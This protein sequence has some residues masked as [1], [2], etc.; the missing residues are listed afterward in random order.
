VDDSLPLWTLEE[1]D[2]NSLHLSRKFVCKN[3]HSALDC[4]NSCGAIAE[5][6]G[7]HPDFHVTNYREV[8]ICM[9]THSVSGITQNDVDLCGMLDKEVVVSYSPKWLKQHP[10]A[11]RHE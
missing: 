4:I 10:E 5:R 11:I 2:D 6:E 9:W 1:N 8:E 3:F 7:H